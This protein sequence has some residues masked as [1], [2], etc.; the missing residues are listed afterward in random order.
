MSEAEGAGLGP[1]GT[2]EALAGPA[3]AQLRGEHL[4]A[5]LAAQQF[6]SRLAAALGL[7]GAVI[8][9][10]RGAEV[11]DIPRASGEPTEPTT[12]GQE[13]GG[14]NRGEQR[15]ARDRDGIK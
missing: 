6:A 12:D 8:S 2:G 10:L 13:V 3:G 4:E 5:F 11:P 14:A 15:A 7:I 1:A 9:V